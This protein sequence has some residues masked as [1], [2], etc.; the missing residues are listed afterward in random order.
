MQI[1]HDFSEELKKNPTYR[2]SEHTLSVLT[3]TSNVVYGKKTGNTPDGRRKGMPFAP[4]ANP[5][6]G[7]D[8][9]G[10]LA[11]L[12]SVAKLPYACCRDGISNTFSILPPTLGESKEERIDNLVEMINGYFL[13]LAHHLNVNV[14]DRSKLVEAMENP[15][16][17]PNLT[18]RISGYAVNFHKL[19]R[20]QQMEI[21]QRTYHE[22]V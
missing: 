21:L 17:Y 14:L 7:R 16:K 15:D 4:G 13:Q 11:S 22:K 3:I 2:D 8:S 9:S 19:T 20:E 6:H 12:N 5:M 1:L 18:I 10:A